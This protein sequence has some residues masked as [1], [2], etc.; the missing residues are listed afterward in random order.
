M[1]LVDITI[2][3]VEQLQP[4]LTCNEHPIKV[5]DTNDQVTTHQMVKFYK[6]QLSNHSEIE[7]TWE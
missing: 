3:N 5:L 2:A 1:P 6:I 7:A 4:D